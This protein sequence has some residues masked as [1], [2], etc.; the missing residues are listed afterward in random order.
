M[1]GSLPPGQPHAEAALL[2][3]FARATRTPTTR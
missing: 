1:L 2:D 3:A